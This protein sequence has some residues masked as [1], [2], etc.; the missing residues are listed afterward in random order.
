ML[1]HHQA[2]AAYNHVLEVLFK[3]EDDVPLYKALE[4]A[5]GYDDIHQ[6]LTVS[7]DDINALTYPDAT[8]NDKPLPFYV[9]VRICILKAYHLHR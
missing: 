4:A 1:T 9:K 5:R 6:L 8:G 7:Y 3:L 2:K